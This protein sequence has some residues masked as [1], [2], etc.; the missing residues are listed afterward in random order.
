MSFVYKFKRG[1][2]VFFYNTL[3]MTYDLRTKCLNGNVAKLKN[4]TMLK[5]VYGL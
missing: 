5:N 2:L 4:V 3:K 1:S